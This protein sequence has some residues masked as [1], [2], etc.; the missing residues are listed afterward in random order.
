M[1]VTAWVFFILILMVVPASAKHIQHE[2]VY[3]QQWCSAVGGVTE[4]RLP[5]RTRVD[6][7]TDDYAIEFD[8]APKWAE[9]IGQALYYGICTDR[10]AGVVLIMEKETDTRYLERL[11][12]VAE[13]HG[14]RV[15]AMGPPE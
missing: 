9:S 4:Y 11:N 15:W 2:K 7:L 5:D 10:Q 3:Q 8:F 6:C 13:Q 12:A 1:K 14:I